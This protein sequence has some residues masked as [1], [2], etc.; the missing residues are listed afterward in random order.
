M[1]V[2]KRFKSGETLISAANLNKTGYNSLQVHAQDTP[3]MTLKIEDGAFIIGGVIIKYAG[4]NSPTITAP[5]SNPRID[6]ITIDSAGTVAVTAGA[7]AGSPSAP[8]YPA[9]KLPLAEIYLRVGATSIKDE[10]D[11]TNGY[12]YKDVRPLVLSQAQSATYMDDTD[13]FKILSD[14]GDGSDGALTISSGVTNIDLG[15]AQMVVKQYTS[16]SIT[17]TG[18]LTFS[19]PHASGTYIVFKVQGNVTLTSSAN[20]NIDASG[21]GAAG[22]AGG[23]GKVT[24]PSNNGANGTNGYNING[25]TTQYG[26]GGEGALNGTQTTPAGGLILPNLSTYPKAVLASFAAIDQLNRTANFYNRFQFNTYLACGSGGGGGG[27]GYGNVSYNGGDGGRGGGVFRMHIGGD[28]NMTGNISVAGKNGTNGVSA[29]GTNDYRGGGG[30]GGGAGGMALIIYNTATATSGSIDTKGGNGGN[31]GNSISANNATGK[32]GAGGSG[33]GAYGGAGGAA[34]QGVG[35]GANG[36]AG[37]G[38]SAG[39]GGGGAGQTTGA[40]GETRAGGTG[41]AGGASDN[42]LKVTYANL[43]R[44]I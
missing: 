27:G 9:G 7:E 23:V 11:T 3:D 10:D 8:T 5:S 6:V 44:E 2:P 35:P 24:V 42:V 14:T 18:Q 13:A 21:M 19:N 28:L 36:S 12:V 37:A 33:G 20:P 43:N 4:G 34:A 17:G 16:I 26:T 38:T 15:A 40:S 32:G 1:P 39:G 31:G 41:G 22:G 25:A 30:G 29:S